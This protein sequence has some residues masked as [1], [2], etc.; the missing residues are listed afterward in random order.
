MINEISKKYFLNYFALQRK[1]SIS[2]FSLGAINQV[3]LSKNTN[4]NNNNNNTNTTNTTTTTTT[5]T[6][7]NNNNNNT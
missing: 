1:T 5:T 7:N 3:K 4:N 6:N 2:I